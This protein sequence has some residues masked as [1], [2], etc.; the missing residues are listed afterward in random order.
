MYD[1]L[2]YFLKENFSLIS[3][4]NE[5]ISF[6]KLNPDLIEYVYKI[7]SV[8]ANEFPGEELIIKVITLFEDPILSVDV[9]TSCSGF[10]A[11]NKMDLVDSSFYTDSFSLENILL[12][13]R[14]K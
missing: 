11:A 6:L 10:D 5:V 7:P 1:S 2:E 9:K 13:V 4:F 12:D 8:Y 3:D 14:F